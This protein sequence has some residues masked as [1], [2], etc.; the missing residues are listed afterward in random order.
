MNP[1]ASLRCSE[2]TTKGLLAAFNTDVFNFSAVRPVSNQNTH[3]NISI[4]FTL[5][6][7]LGVVS[8]NKD[9]YSICSYQEMYFDW[10]ALILSQS[11]TRANV[12][13]ACCFQD[14]KAQI[15]ETFIWQTM[16]SILHFQVNSI[17]FYTC[18]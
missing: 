5:Y 1:V 6:A 15:L 14:E 17:W 2:P 4:Y 3:T 7:I 8:F 18:Q 9:V 12:K 11:V 16:V 13:I 10:S